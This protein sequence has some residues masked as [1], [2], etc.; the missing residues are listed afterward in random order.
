[1]G[2]SLVELQKVLGIDDV[3][4][5]DCL[6]LR[7]ISGVVQGDKAGR[8]TNCRALRRIFALSF[9]IWVREGTF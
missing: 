3:T 9:E 7:R 2:R 1:M 4:Q 6:P 8:A 5:R